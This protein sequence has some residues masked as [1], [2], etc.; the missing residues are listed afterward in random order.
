[1][2]DRPC[3]KSAGLLILSVTVAAIVGAWHQHPGSASFGTASSLRATTAAVAKTYPCPACA[4]SHQL[5]DGPQ[6]TSTVTARPVA[7]AHPAPAAGP[8]HLID[9]VTLRPPRAPPV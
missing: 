9:C 7:E 1:M 5:A 3:R 6:K 4:L 8:V 2:H